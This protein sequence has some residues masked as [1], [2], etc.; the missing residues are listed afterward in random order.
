MLKDEI[1]FLKNSLELYQPKTEEE[2]HVYKFLKKHAGEINKLFKEFQAEQVYIQD[3]LGKQNYTTEEASY[4]NT[5][6]DING[7]LLGCVCELYG[8]TTKK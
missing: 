5:L 7:F 8:K 6:A 1:L 4:F 2:K 3:K